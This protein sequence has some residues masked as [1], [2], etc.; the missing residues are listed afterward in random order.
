MDR[1]V[2][3]RPPE[4]GP[5]VPLAW[6]QYYARHADHDVW[7]TGNP[8]LCREAGIPFPREA[9]E[10]LVA[11]DQLWAVVGFVA[12]T[13]IVVHGISVNPVM[14]FLD[15]IREDPHGGPAKSEVS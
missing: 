2:D 15:R 1:T 9:R 6:I 11:A 8:R 3:V 13:S 10:L 12:L 5:A 7:A 14:S 4:R